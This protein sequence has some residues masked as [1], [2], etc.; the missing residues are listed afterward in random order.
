MDKQSGPRGRD[1]PARLI[2]AQPEE[3]LSDSHGCPETGRAARA[4]VSARLCGD[5]GWTSPGPAVV[6]GGLREVAGL[7]GVGVFQ[8]ASGLL[9]QV[10]WTGWAVPRKA[11]LLVPFSTGSVPARLHVQSQTKPWPA[12]KSP[13]YWD[14]GAGETG[15]VRTSQ[16]QRGLGA[17]P[18]AGSPDKTPFVP[19]W[20]ALPRSA[21]REPG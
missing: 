10:S 2:S 12:P 14:R 21:Q 9:T 3:E 5:A 4:A 6:H 20:A 13:Q 18:L 1:V 19:G 17:G 8:L 15:V 16:G 7:G 11:L